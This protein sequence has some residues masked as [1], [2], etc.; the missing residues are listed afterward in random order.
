[1]TVSYKK[2][3]YVIILAKNG[4]KWPKMTNIL[5]KNGSIGLKIGQI[6]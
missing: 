6:V 2:K 5:P 1:M 4:K 3:M